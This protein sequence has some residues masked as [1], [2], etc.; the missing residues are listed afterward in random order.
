LYLDDNSASHKLVQRLRKAR[1]DVESPSD[2]GLVGE[3]D[4]I[5][6]T[7]AIL[8]GR[9]LLTEDYTDFKKLHDLLK[10]GQGHHPGILVVRNDN[11]SKKDLDETGIVRAIAK[12]VAA[13][14]PVADEYII[15]NHWR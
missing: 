13:K 10:A 6:L 4:P 9:A 15:L 1:H 8:T 11:N 5:H 7:H 14:V 2:A 3:D 12:L